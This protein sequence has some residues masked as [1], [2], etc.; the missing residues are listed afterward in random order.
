MPYATLHPAMECKRGGTSVILRGPS[1]RCKRRQSHLTFRF[2]KSASIF[3]FRHSKLA[4]GGMSA[5][6]ST[7]IVLIK[8]AMPLAP[9]RCPIFDLTAPLSTIISK[10]KDKVFHLPD[11]YI[12]F[13][14]GKNL[15]VE[16]IIWR[17]IVSKGSANS[18]CLCWIT[19]SST[20]TY[21]RITLRENPWTAE[22]TYHELQS[23][24]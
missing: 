12:V 13:E 21:R 5:F 2:R 1:D 10:G 23:I 14:P 19:N 24:A 9:S 17:P 18:T 8:P 6:S 22:L 4:F 15:H 7:I 16:R 3:G 11:Q 20:S